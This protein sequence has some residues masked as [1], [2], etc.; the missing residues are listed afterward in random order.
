MLSDCKGTHFCLNGKIFVC[1]IAR[2][3]KPSIAA[4]HKT[5]GKGYG[6]I[7]NHLLHHDGNRSTFAPLIIQQKIGDIN[8]FTTVSLI[9]MLIVGTVFSIWMAKHD[10]LEVS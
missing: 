8:M 3:S 1:K 4:M 10:N 5:C 2:L 9:V 6:I 7:H